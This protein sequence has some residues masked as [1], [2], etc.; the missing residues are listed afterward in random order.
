MSAYVDQEI[1]LQHTDFGWIAI[2]EE[3]EISSAPMPTRTEALD[4]LDE[5]IALAEGNLGFSTETERAI[6]ES[7]GELDRGETVSHDKLK[8]ELGL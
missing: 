3:R 8:R 4:D 6:E 2:D 5:N 1:T 7:E